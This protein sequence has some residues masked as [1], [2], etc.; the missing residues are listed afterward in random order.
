MTCAS[1]A[2]GTVDSFAPDDFL[3]DADSPDPEFYRTPRF[4]EHL[5]STALATVEALYA[6]LIPKGAGILDLM[7]GPASHLP[8]DREPDSVTG[9][10]LN[11][12]ELQSNP[13][14]SRWVVHDLNADP[15]LPFEDNHFD[16]VV[17]TVSVDYLVRPVEVFR[18]VGRILSPGGLFIVVFSNRYFPPKAVALW[19]RST[20]SQRVDLVKKFFALAQNFSVDGG[21]E[22]KGKP[23]PKDDKY[24][25]LGIP[26]DPVYAVWAKVVK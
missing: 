24:Y 23:R 3:R 25:S 22:S 5:D 2:K 12:E 9:L 19:R 15:I 21:L 13:A 14:I 11:A 4:V 16:V 18:E 10:G 7:A 26:S 20:E 17:N 1:T 8:R 6:R